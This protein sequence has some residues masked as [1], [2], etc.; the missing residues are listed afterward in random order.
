MRALAPRDLLDIWDHSAHQDAVERALGIVRAGC[1]ELSRE[2]SF[3]L[4]VGER[5]ARLF[6]LHR[7]TFNP[8]LDGYAECPICT[9]PVEFNLDIGALDI[10]LDHQ[11]RE[12]A[13][14]A[15]GIQ[16]EFRLPDSRD[17][18]EVVGVADVEA[19][20]KTLVGR[21][22]ISASR[23]GAS[24]AAAELP[25]AV[26]TEMAHSMASVQPAADVV[27]NLSCPACGH[28][29]ETLLD[30]TAFIWAEIT[31]TAKRLLRTVHT[32]ARAYGWGEDEILQLSEQRRADYVALVS[33]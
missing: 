31:A 14:K 10:A 13:L 3:A 21:C 19:G 8:V 22:V 15:A 9:T 32:L 16:V 29:W 24:I 4:T 30:I 5:D 25:S 20:R 12:G 2:A 28:H 17:L 26:V 33:A 1:P 11:R 27:L 23:D 18:L 6:Q 7:L